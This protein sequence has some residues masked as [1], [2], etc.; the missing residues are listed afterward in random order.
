MRVIARAYGDEPLQRIVTGSCG[1]L[2]YLIN[3]SLDNANGIRP[4]SGVGFPK[5]SIYEFEL[6]TFESLCLAWRSG[7]PER[8]RR[9]WGMTTPMEEGVIEPA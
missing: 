1:N 9:A 7:D 6:A 5:S 8:L 4:L 3:P 2:V